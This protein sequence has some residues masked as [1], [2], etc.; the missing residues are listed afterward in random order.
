MKFVVHR[1]RRYRAM[2]K[3]TISGSLQIQPRTQTGASAT[4]HCEIFLL[5]TV[6]SYNRKREQP[7][8]SGEADVTTQQRTGVMHIYI[9]RMS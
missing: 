9:I 6:E 7:S 4:S 1:D 5:Y 3:V 8:R 2:E